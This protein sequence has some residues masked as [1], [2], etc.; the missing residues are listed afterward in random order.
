LRTTEQR[1]YGAAEV[2]DGDGHVLEPRDLWTKEL[3]PRW[4]DRALSVQW[5][6][7]SE[8]EYQTCDGVAMNIGLGTTNGWARLPRSIRD[9]PRGLRWEDLTPAGLTGPDRVVELDR[10]GI[11]RAVLYPSQGLLLGGLTDP[12]LATLTARIYNDWLA[13]FCSAAPDR[14]VGVAAVPMQDPAAAAVEA[15]RAVRELGFRGVFVRPNPVGDIHPHDSVYDP[16]WD[17][18]QGLDIPVGLHAA[19]T[20]DTFG[21]ARTFG[22]LWR[23]ITPLGK[24]I[25]FMVDTVQSFTMIIAAG[26]LDRFPSL[27]VAV[28]EAGV[29]WLHWWTDKID[30]WNEARIAGPSIELK[31]SEYIDRQ[32]WISGDPDEHSLA[33]VT[34]IVPADRL[35]WASDFPHLDLLEN[36]PSVTAEL[37][38]KLELIDRDVAVKILGANAVDLYGLEP[39]LVV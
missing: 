9:D 35:I 4:R 34:S 26:V 27:K 24:P 23:G 29:G 36:E 30:H 12:E 7:D 13:E 8:T 20:A 6:P 22:P 1:P 16:L 38:E 18:C 11:D 14:L 33:T 10:E 5:D 15:E 25:N 31:P 21:M 19:G 3:P 17:V 2:I 28:L 39:A 32:V 37:Y